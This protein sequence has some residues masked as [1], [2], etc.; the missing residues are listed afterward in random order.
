LV[1]L[2]FFLELRAFG[3]GDTLGDDIT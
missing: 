1:A 3:E 2:L